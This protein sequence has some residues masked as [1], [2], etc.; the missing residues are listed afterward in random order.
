M[1][2]TAVLLAV[3]FVSV[4]GLVQDL[5][6]KTATKKAVPVKAP[7][8]SDV[9]VTKNADGTVEASDAPAATSPSSYSPTAKPGVTYRPAPP[10]TFHYGD[11][12]VVR[13]NA[14]GSVD[15]TDEESSHPTFHSFG[16]APA[17]SH[18]ATAHGAHHS[19]HGAVKKKK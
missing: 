16:S 11:G 4:F 5:E 3:S 7:E 18:R 17:S 15:V 10:G 12:V 14:D 2:T 19:S 8:G 9:V 1:R 6:A 13:R